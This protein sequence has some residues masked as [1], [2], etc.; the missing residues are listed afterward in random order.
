MRIWLIGAD[1]SGIEV[2]RQLGKH[3][4]VEV[5][6]SSSVED[7][8]AVREGVIEA[9][10]FIESVTSFNVNRLARRIHP[11][12]ILIDAGAKER[13]LGHVTGGANFS[14]A[15]IF[16]ITAASEFPCVVI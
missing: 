9:V 14:D 16:E 2:L 13:N 15:I 7:P 10:D 8:M 6:V 3:R 11:D 1:E 12:L 4:T 5:I